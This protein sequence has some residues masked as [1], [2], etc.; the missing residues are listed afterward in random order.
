MII[1]W[2]NGVTGEQITVS[3]VAGHAIKIRTMAPENEQA[4]GKH[5]NGRRAGDGSNTND[6][7]RG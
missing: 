7:G 2:C 5:P 4:G 6:A 3:R 1:R